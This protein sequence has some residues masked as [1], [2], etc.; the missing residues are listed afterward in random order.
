M[1]AQIVGLGILCFVG[2]MFVG[3]RFAMKAAELLSSKFE[4]WKAQNIKPVEW[5]DNIGTGVN[6]V[7]VPLP[8]NTINFPNTW[9][10]SSIVNTP[11]I[12]TVTTTGTTLPI[13]TIAYLNGNVV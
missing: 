11:A 6:G 5:W 1:I 13:S 3:G 7:N 10:G 4:K 2:G 12:S 9:G 8:P